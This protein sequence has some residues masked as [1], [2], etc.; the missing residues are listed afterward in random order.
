MASRPRQRSSR[1]PS[2]CQSA[3]CEPKAYGASA[4]AASRS[5]RQT[6]QS[7]S[8]STRVSITLEGCRRSGDQA[9]RFRLGH[10]RASNHEAQWSRAGTRCHRNGRREQAF[11]AGSGHKS[12]TVKAAH[13]AGRA[14]LVATTG[15]HRPT[16]PATLGDDRD[17]E[18][19]R[20]SAPNPDPPRRSG[21][22]QVAATATPT[23][24][25]ASPPPRQ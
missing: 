11:A 1:S 20:D 7:P 12:V 24:G 22:G 4:S 5:S 3:N 10:R 14:G 6:F 19:P 9:M 13:K 25:P 16:R 17:P 18:G 8:A 23:A 2:P 21:F 15:R